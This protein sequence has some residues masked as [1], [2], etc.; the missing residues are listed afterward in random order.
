[1][2]SLIANAPAAEPSLTASA[3]ALNWISQERCKAA[4]SLTN[5]LPATSK[6][7]VESP[8]FVTGGAAMPP[9][10]ETEAV[11]DAD[12]DAVDVVETVLLEN[13]ALVNAAP[14]DEA[15]LATA[16][17]FRFEELV[18]AGG[19]TVMVWVAIQGVDSLDAAVRATPEAAEISVTTAEVA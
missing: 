10:E 2:Q 15:W 18:T 1:M 4:A 11:E 9:S 6:G 19:L 17:E 12:A 3:H 16:V 7:R 14:W 13:G 5:V 8:E